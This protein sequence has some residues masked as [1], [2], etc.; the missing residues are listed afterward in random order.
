[1]KLCISLNRC[2]L[3]LFR[4]DMAEEMDMMRQQVTSILSQKSVIHIDISSSEN[5][6]STAKKSAILQ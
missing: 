5:E 3:Q 6:D 4:R 1:M 2:L